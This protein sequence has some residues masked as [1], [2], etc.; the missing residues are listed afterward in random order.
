M[1]SL[2]A[3]FILRRFKDLDKGTLPMTP[4]IVQPKMTVKDV[5]YMLFKAFLQ[6]HPDAIIPEDLEKM[7]NIEFVIVMFNQ[8]ADERNLR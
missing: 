8:E 3:M 5:W 7:L 1:T 2:D 6:T 4:S